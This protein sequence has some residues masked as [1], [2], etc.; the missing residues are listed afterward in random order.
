MKG[1]RLEY[2]CVVGDIDAFGSMFDSSF[3]LTVKTLTHLL[4][5]QKKRRSIEFN[6]TERL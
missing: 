2:Y 3:L 5:N 1:V 6:I 4:T